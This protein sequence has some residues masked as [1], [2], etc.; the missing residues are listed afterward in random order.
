MTGVA[1]ADTAGVDMTVIGELGAGRTTGATG[2]E[3]TGSDI[4][5]GT[6]DEITGVVTTGG[7]GTETASFP[8]IFHRLLLSS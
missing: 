7:I 5:E 1:G 2:A 3:T 6:G 4:T 8:K